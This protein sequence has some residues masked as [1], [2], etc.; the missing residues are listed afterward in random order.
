MYLYKIYCFFFL[1]LS[2]FWR[3]NDEDPKL[4]NS[5]SYLVWVA[6]FGNWFKNQTAP[7]SMITVHTQRTAPIHFLYQISVYAWNILLVWKIDRRFNKTEEF[8][9]LMV[10]FQLNKKYAIK[11]PVSLRPHHFRYLASISKFR[12]LCLKCPEKG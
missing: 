4:W 2:K 12:I 9:F 5:F 11:A 8:Y 7:L 6:Y 1:S 3:W 10:P